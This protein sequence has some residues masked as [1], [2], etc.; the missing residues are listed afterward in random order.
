MKKP[1]KKIVIVGRDADAWL[2]AF[3]LQRSFASSE[4]SIEV[5]LIELPS[6]L[7]AQDFYAVLPSHKLL[8]TILGANEN[9]L[10]GSCAGL[11]ALAQRFSNWS[12]SAAPFLHAYDTQGASIGHVDFFQ[13]WLKARSK[14]LKVPLEDFSLG[15]VAAKQGRF[16][17]L[18]ESV[19][20]FSK[21]AHGY[22]LSAVPYVRALAN[23]ALAAGLIHRK[24]DVQSVDIEN[25]HIKSL[26]L[27]D[28]TRIYGDF[29]IDAS[30]VDASLISHLETNN[31]ENWN[32]WLPCDRILVASA[33]ILEPVPAFSQISAFSEGWA[34]F[35]PLLNRTAVTIAYS[36]KYASSQDVL[37]K[38]AAFS[39]IKMGDAVESSFSAGTRKKHWIGNC[40]AL[41]NS[42]VCLEPLDATQLHMLHTG[43][44][45]LRSLFPV[46][47]EAM[48]EADVF[49]EKMYSHAVNVR[50]F[51]IAHYQLNKRFGDPFWDQVRDVQ[52][53]ASLAAKINLFE[54]RGLIAMHEDE[55]FQEENWT[56][57]LIGH[58]LVPKTYDPLVDETAE[59]EQFERFQQ[60]L[61]YIATEIA[62]M[63][64]LQAHIEMS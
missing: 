31:Y 8:H 56:F 62:N 54:S 5:Q 19:R 36:S 15:A 14:G 12:G 17:L 9:K 34:G 39:G 59:S 42:A 41:G 57:V 3:L 21:A 53:P 10:L 32:Q 51:Q 11:Y 55:T 22:H 37:Q 28:N 38:V 26:V 13:H 52:P 45:L 29:F 20:A 60:M 7:G 6:D 50:D 64:S 49:N 63:P 16:V 58:G 1:I 61:K 2:T 4:N 25:G 27:T 43:L 18:D 46:D 30:G 24:S 48:P 47:A 40:L 23:A 35:F 33:P 44:S